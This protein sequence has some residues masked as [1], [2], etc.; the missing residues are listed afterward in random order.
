MER[1]KSNYGV[2]EF[3]RQEDFQNLINVFVSKTTTA[4]EFDSA[5]K[6]VCYENFLNVDPGLSGI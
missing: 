6:T 5:L 2:V 3:G 1:V 4:K